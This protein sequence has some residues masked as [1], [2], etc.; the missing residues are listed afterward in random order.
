LVEDWRLRVLGGVLIGLTLVITVLM[1]APPGSESKTLLTLFR[2][3]FTLLGFA[4]LVQRFRRISPADRALIENPLDRSTFFVDM[5]LEAGDRD[6]G[7]DRGVVWMDG[8]ALYCTGHACS[9]CIG[10]QDVLDAVV[11]GRRSKIIEGKGYEGY[12]LQLRP[13]RENLWVSITPIKRKEWPDQTKA[14][15]SAL[16]AFMADGTPTA[17]ER[18]YP[19]FSDRSKKSR[20][21]NSQ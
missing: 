9:F 10:R 19:P 17:E 13:A 11:A 4:V 15:A 7:S 3:V 21:S 2:S 18:E 8:S 1:L 16:V 20:K 5:T 12:S 6:A 14:L